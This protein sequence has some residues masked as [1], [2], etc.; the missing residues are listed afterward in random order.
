MYHAQ[1]NIMFYADEFLAKKKGIPEET[2]IPFKLVS[3][4][5]NGSVPSAH[6]FD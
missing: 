5:Q 4:G 2:I 6:L 1:E 3:F